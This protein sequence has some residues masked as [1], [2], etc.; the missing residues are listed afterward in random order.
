MQAALWPSLLCLPIVAFFLVMAGFSRVELELTPAGVTYKKRVGS[1]AMQTHTVPLQTARF[2]AQALG[3]VIKKS[4]P[5]APASLRLLN[6]SSAEDRIVRM[7][8]PLEAC[9]HIAHTLN[10]DIHKFKSRSDLL[11]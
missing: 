6:E 7:G 10:A 9:V 8:L 2:Q 3:A 5:A 11:D 4:D 1:W